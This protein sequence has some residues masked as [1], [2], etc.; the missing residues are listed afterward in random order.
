M[1]VDARAPLLLDANATEPVLD[2][3]RSALLDAL[4]LTGNASSTHAAGRRARRVLDDARAHVAAAL[5][6]APREVVFM[7]GASEGNRFL[8][9]ALVETARRKHGATRPPRIAS[10]RLEHP[11]LARALA[12]R[13]ETGEIALTLLDVDLR[14]RVDGRAARDH[15]AVFVTAAHNET[16]IV[17]ALDDVL[18]EIDDA[19]LVCCDA[20]QAVARLAPLPARVDAVVC[21]GHKMGAPAGTG[22]L[23]RRGRALTLASPWAGGAQE[24]GHRPG[25]EALVLIAALGAAASVVERSRARASAL[26]PLRDAF[27]TRVIARIP[28]ARVV[29]GDAPRLPQTTAIC[30]HGVDGDALRI[31]TDLRGLAVGFG[32]ACSALSPEPS[33]ALLALGLDARAAR[34]TVRVSL[35][36]GAL[37]AVVVDNAADRLIDVVH[38]I[39]RRA[40]PPDVTDP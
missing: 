3:A 19:T 20:A 33:T 16:G 26:A 30:F 27:E 28:S 38:A 17:P 25:T 31:E 6:G 15:D 1:T 36:H 24:G 8:V 12:A 23:L 2:E 4:A 40:R 37:D 14:G 32:S 34:S 7:S 39:E 13:A 9:D 35:S 21:S 10:T 29:G 11:S 5:G 22:A 18:A